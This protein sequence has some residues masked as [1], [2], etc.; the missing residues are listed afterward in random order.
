MSSFR[1]LAIVSTAATIE[2][3]AI[4][5]LVRATK[6]GLGCGTD[7][8]SCSGKLL[9]A[10]ESR[11]LVIEYSHRVTASLVVLLLVGL[12]ALAIARRRDAP[13]LVWPS[14]AAVGLVLSQALLGLL[15]VKLELEAI[16]V[17][18]HLGAAMALLA[19][20]V[21]IVIAASTVVGSPVATDRGVSRA[22][23]FAAISVLVLLLV[24][25]FVTGR[26]A[27]LAFPDWPLMDGRVIPDLGAGPDAIHFAHRALAL[28]VGIIVFRLGLTVA[29]RK[30]ELPVQAKLAHAA[31][32]LYSVEVALGAVNV[33]TELNAAAVSLHLLLGALIW[34][35]LVGLAVSSH[36]GIARPATD[37]AAAPRAV[38][39]PGR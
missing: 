31:M 9:P 10:L 39:E 24:G 11:A 30:A 8:P 36:P 2:L 22:A 27:G 26:A 28:V 14:V 13:N 4:G 7:W 16:S 29:R 5:G 18:L 33:W 34:G 17:T 35:V 3:I 20:L 1:R 21:Y 15:V 12:A 6:S 19:L 38:L 37:R 25:S 23:G 32:G